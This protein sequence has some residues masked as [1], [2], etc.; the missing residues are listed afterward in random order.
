[1]NTRINLKSRLKILGAGKTIKKNMS[2]IRKL[3]FILLSLMLG[4]T[5]QFNAFAQELDYAD[6][7]GKAAEIIKNSEQ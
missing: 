2:N 3:F 1:M 6:N 4:L 5:W 7:S